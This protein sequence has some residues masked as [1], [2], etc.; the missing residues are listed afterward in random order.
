M[1]FALSRTSIEACMRDFK[2][3]RTEFQDR[4]GLAAEGLGRDER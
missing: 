2:W 3:A 4:I 1:K